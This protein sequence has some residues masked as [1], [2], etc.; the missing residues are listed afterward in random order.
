MELPGKHGSPVA[1]SEKQDSPTAWSE[2][3]GCPTARSEKQGSPT[4]W[5]ERQG[6]LTA[7]SEDKAVLLLGVR[8]V[9]REKQGR[10]LESS[11]K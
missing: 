5:S 6:C 8:I 11:K 1:R 4:A 3:Q 7:R 2:R 9:R 10:L